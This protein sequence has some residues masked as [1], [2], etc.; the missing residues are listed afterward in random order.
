MVKLYEGLYFVLL[1][2]TKEVNCVYRSLTI[3][4]YNE[5][6]NNS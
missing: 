6:E 3:L 5:K 1:K 4:T 2:F